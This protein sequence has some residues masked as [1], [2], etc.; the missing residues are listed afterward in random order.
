M[1]AKPYLQRS[2]ILCIALTVPLAVMA[3]EENMETILDIHHILAYLVAAFLISVFV[4]IFFNRVI[5]YRERDVTKQ[6][7]Q[8][9][10]QLSLVM[11][12][13]KTAAWTY[14]AKHDLYKIVA[15]Q[16]TSETTYTPFEFSQFYD[17]NDFT[18]LLKVMSK[19]RERITPS[20]T[21]IVRS[22]PI[23]SESGKDYQHIYEITITVLRKGKSGF[24]LQLLG[25][26]RDIT[27]E[28]QRA[29]EA[30]RTA[31]R[32]QTL[33]DS[34]LVDMVYFDG[35]GTML[36]IN[37]KACESYFIKDRKALIAKKPKYTD[38]PSMRDIDLT[39]DTPTPSSS[40]VD[41]KNVNN[42]VDSLASHDWGGDKIYFER[43]TTLLRDKD[44]K[45]NGIMMA[46]RNIT[47]MVNSFHQQK[48][49]SLLIES[50]IKDI[51][52]YIQN[53]N[54][55]LKV[56]DV[57]MVNYHPDTHNLDISSD[58]NA[59]EYTLPQLRAFIMVH[60]DDY[61]KAERLFCRMDRLHPGTFSETVRTIIRDNQGRHV[62]L[63]F[64]MMPITDS[65]G[66]IT[67]YF[68]MCRNETEMTY[69]ELRL[70]EETEKAQEEERLKN[71]FLLN[72]SH[73]LRTPLNAVIGFAEL[74]NSE[75]SEED[76]PIF[77]EEIKKNTGVLLALINDI[78]FLSRL[79]ARMIEYNYQECDFAMLF[80]G[81]CYMGWSNLQPNVKAVVDNP[82]NRLLVNIDQQNLGMVIQKLCTHSGATTKE[83]TVRA[84]YEYRHGEL[85]ITIDDTSKG[86]SPQ[87][88]E[89]AFNRFANED[90]NDAE[91]TGLD[92]PIVKE[93]IEQM[94][95]S[96]EVQSERDKGT[97][98]FVT[99]P[100][101]MGVLEK[102]VQEL[103]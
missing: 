34:S 52:Q 38:W 80:E 102:K 9:I 20:E 61:A 8:L 70:Q 10:A 84:K 99:I 79:D 49:T 69:T 59:T 18:E 42:P 82:Y 23:K 36:D 43:T 30:K 66:Q 44:G 86:M 90:N 11:T 26:Q 14:D 22:T 93:L 51:Q 71:T 15:E 55:S 95:G 57:R 87:E 101:E 50:R 31:M 46:G 94:G 37:D 21:I 58:L 65:E 19:V 103:I 63:N 64:N 53:I 2:I 67:H 6:G 68:G 4:M 16:G 76:E 39:S 56:S 85:N 74:F 73:E 47:D 88:L 27:D 62:Y 92:L 78:L 7:K 48:K 3:Q 17:R 75:H 41:L 25:T 35:E 89:N 60:P 32:Y 24:P 96:I 45:L 28:Q 33:F 72:M 12:S 40:I 98:F 77:A 100:C 54:Y 81:W 5:Y 13:N 91:G 83:G 29:E 1:C 97:T